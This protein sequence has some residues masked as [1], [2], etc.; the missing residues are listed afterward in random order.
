MASAGAMVCSLLAWLVVGLLA[1]PLAVATATGGAL[2]AGAG[3]L[4][5]LSAS[6]LLLLLAQPLVAGG[7]LKVWVTA[8]SDAQ[9]GFG[10]ASLAMMAALGVDVLA[11]GALP[12]SLAMPLL[13]YSWTGA[14]AAGLIVSG[15]LR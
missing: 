6:A 13:G 7:L 5:A 3:G 8:L 15:G 2:S 11:A 4:A 9:L 12:T 14:I 10:L 1:L